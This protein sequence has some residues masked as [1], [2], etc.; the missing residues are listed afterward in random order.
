MMNG[1]E[2]FNIFGFKVKEEPLS[3]YPYSPVYRVKCGVVVKRTQ[4]RAKN[5]KR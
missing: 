2:I 1:K 5:A 3:I 4:R